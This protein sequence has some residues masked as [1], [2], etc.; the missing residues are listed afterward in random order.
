M[1]GL[2]VGPVEPFRIGLECRQARIR[3]EEKGSAAIFGAREIL[4]IR[5]VED[6]A[7]QRNEMR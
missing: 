4:R 5:V 1:A 6:P 3:A 2:P 7:A